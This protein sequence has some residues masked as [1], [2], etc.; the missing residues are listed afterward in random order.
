MER[1]VTGIKL[2]PLGD[3]VIFSKYAGTEKTDRG[4]K[5]EG[6]GS[7]QKKSVLTL[8]QERKWKRT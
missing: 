7:W 3:R 2:R 5:K 8:L 1:Q 6:I 4:L